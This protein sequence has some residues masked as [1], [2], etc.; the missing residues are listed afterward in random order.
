MCDANKMSDDGFEMWLLCRLLEKEE[1]RNRWRTAVCANFDRPTDS[2]AT[3]VS[4]ENTQLIVV[5]DEIESTLA[6]AIDT[7]L[8]NGLFFYYDF[9][10]ICLFFCTGCLDRTNGR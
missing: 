4:V 2:T 1:F 8:T 3:A 10:P 7:Y 9:F 5:V 6:V